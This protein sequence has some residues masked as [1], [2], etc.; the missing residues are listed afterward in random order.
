MLHNIKKK[1]WKH[2]TKDIVKNPKYRQRIFELKIES[3][4]FDKAIVPSNYQEDAQK[5]TALR[6]LCSRG[7]FYS[8]SSTI[9][10]LL[11]EFNNVTVVG[12]EEAAWSKSTVSSIRSEC[13][14]FCYTNFFEMLDTF[15]SQNSTEQSLAIVS[16]IRAFEHAYDTKRTAPH[17]YNPLLYGEKFRDICNELM[18][19]ILELDENTL[20]TVKQ[21]GF[22]TNTY[23]HDFK[24]CNFIIGEGK[25]SYLYYQFKHISDDEFKSK[26]QRFLNS[27]FRIIKSKDIVLYDQLL[28]EEKL[29]QINQYMEIPVKQV[30]VY[31]DPRDRFVSALKS[32]S[33]IVQRN[34]KEY[35]NEYRARLNAHP[36]CENRL[37][38]RF[39]DIVLRYDETVQKIISFLGLDPQNHVAPKS[40]FDPAI[41]VANIGAWRSYV[42]QDFMREIEELMG[43]YCY[44]PERENLSDESLA[45]LK[46]SGNWDDSSFASIF[47]HQ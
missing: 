8:G 14:F 40:V 25:H 37:N 9:V 31:R 33:N 12:F 11:N 35:V 5:Q 34:A 22:P 42:D 16:F 46:S 18:I 13:C 26:V 36:P 2:L 20:L 30:C 38:V 43:D 17:E 29:E 27:F 1:I 6:I 10:G 45:L 39:E 7:H 3:D 44:Y 4:L 24:Q 41:S 47:N 21:K 32:G 19:D 15:H 28:K 23:N